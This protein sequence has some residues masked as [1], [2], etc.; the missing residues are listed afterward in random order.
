M[1]SSWSIEA[2]ADH[3]GLMCDSAQSKRIL[4]PPTWELL[5]P[6]EGY[7]VGP[8]VSPE[9]RKIFHHNGGTLPPTG[10]VSYRLTT[11]LP[12]Y[13]NDQKKFCIYG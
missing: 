11:N 2:Q 13:S 8:K 5:S 6:I 1:P 10:G 7:H 4:F 9:L 3:N 12:K